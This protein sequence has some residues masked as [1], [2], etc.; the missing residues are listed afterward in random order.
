MEPGCMQSADATIS[1]GARAESGTGSSL[2]SAP[3]RETEYSAWLSRG[4]AKRR[5]SLGFTLIELLVVIA[6]IAILA[7]MLLPALARA[8][9]KA[10]T[11]NCLSNQR[12]I[13][14]A[15]SL[16]TADYQDRF[17]YTNEADHRM[18]GL[19]DVWKALQPYLSTN[20]SF[21]VCLADQGGPANL[22]WL[23][24]SGDPANVLA[25]SYITFLRLL[26]PTHLTTPIVTA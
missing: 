23:K 6:I 9:A 21:C 16:Y 1:R 8:K 2:T 5:R 25:S 13:G 14:L 4:S 20:R 22:A 12:Q 10:K 24:S 19:V 18:L 11:A 17:F 3:L 7:A 15:M 26:T